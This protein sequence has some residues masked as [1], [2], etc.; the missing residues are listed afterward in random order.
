MI[1]PEVYGPARIVDNLP[2]ATSANTSEIANILASSHYTEKYESGTFACDTTSEIVWYVLTNAGYDT[3]IMVGTMDNNPD[4]HAW[5]LVKLD[6]G[7]VPIETTGA[8]DVCL[9]GIVELGETVYFSGGYTYTSQDYLRGMMMNS[10]QEYNVF[11]AHS[12]CFAST[13]EY[14]LPIEKE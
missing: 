3:K 14:A 5:V 9:G 13:L 6:R 1:L 11:M 12:R 8:Y 7:Y 10:S 4:P 2:H